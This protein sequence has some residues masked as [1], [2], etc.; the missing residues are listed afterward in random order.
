MTKTRAVLLED[1]L[2][3]IKRLRQTLHAI[4][5]IDD[6]RYISNGRKVDMAKRMALMA[7]MDAEE[8]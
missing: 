1:A 2:D 8:P 7:L 6:Q 4:A 3:E 5:D